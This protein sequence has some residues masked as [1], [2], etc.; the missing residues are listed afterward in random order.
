MTVFDQRNQ[1]VKYQYNAAGN[2]NLSGVKDA[3]EF[4]EELE[5]LKSEV[6]LAASSQT[7]DA[8]IVTDT[9]YQIQKVVDQ[10]QKP[11]PNK[12]LMIDHLSKVKDLLKNIVEVGGI[13]AGISKAIELVQ[14]LF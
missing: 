7:I 10:A 2:I 13:V 14:T 3:S 8:E 5:K 4:I 1:T 9:Q 6:S 12:S 11:D